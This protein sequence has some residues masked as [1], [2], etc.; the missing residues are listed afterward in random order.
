MKEETRVAL[1]EQ[2]IGHI[3][4]TLLRIEKGFDAVDFRFDR[5]EKRI[6]A[7]SDDMKQRIDALS[8]DMKQ[9]FKDINNRMWSNFLWMIGSFAAVLALIAHAVKWI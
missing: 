4:E 9:G 5:I 3:N 6:D 8:D 7:L 1:L 2:S